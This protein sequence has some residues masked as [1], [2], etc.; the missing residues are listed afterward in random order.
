MKTYELTYLISPELK[1]QEIESI[2]SEIR[3]LAQEQDAIVVEN[4]NQGIIKLDNE[5]KNRKT[6]LL[7]VLKFQMDPLKQKL[8]QEKIKKYPKILRYSILMLKPVREK[9]KIIKQIKETPKQKKVELKSIE[10]KLEELLG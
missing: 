10:E 1:G 7:A 9:T 4:S 2:F 8:F 6:V 5:I 3:A